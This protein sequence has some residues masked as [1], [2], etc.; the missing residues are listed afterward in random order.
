ML[1]ADAVRL[2]G[3]G[4]GNLSRRGSLSRELFFS[5]ISLHCS[6]VAIFVCVKERGGLLG[7][8]TF[9]SSSSSS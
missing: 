1:V 2:P 7:F 6:T 5:S 3:L 4:G 8:G 9:P